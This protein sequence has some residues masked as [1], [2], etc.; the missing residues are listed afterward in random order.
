MFD[1]RHL[2]TLATRIP[3][4]FSGIAL[5]RWALEAIHRGGYDAADR[6]FEAAASRYRVELAVEP[7]ARLRVHQMIARVRALDNPERETELSLEVERLLTRLD[8]IES[9]EPPFEL[10]DAGSLL[11][12][13]L[14]SCPA[15]RAP[16]SLAESR[17]AA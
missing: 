7:L 12:T 4:A 10:V 11:A 15:S 17:R 5:H 14:G 9:L 2:W 13:W 8:R 16:G 1:S 6:L 3:Q